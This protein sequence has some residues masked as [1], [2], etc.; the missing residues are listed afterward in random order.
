MA[1]KLLIVGLLCNFSLSRILTASTEDKLFNLMIDILAVSSLSSPSKAIFC[2]HCFFGQ[3]TEWN[4]W[5]QCLREKLVCRL[6]VSALEAIH[7]RSVI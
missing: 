4:L 2:L 5:R 1:I 6:S 3:P 7:R